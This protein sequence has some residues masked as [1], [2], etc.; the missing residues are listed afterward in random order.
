MLKACDFYQH[1]VIKRFLNCFE[2]DIRE[3]FALV[4]QYIFLLFR[5]KYND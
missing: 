2:N 3:K 1:Y 5:I 4:F